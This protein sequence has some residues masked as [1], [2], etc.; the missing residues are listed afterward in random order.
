MTEREAY[1][2][3]NL[4][5]KVGFATVGKLAAQYGSVVAAWEAYPHKISRIGEPV[6]WEKEFSLARKFGVE[7]I[8][9]AD[10]KYPRQLKEAP[11]CPLVLY[12][13]GSVDALSL[14][15]VAM[16]G[17]RRATEYGLGV[18]NRFSYDLCKASWSV[19]SGLALGIDA[20]SHRGALEAK[21]ITVGVIG[22]GLDKFYPQENRELA[23]RIVEQGGA[24]VSEFPFGRPADRATF[25]IRNHVVAALAKGTVAVEAPSRSGTLITAGIAA[26]IGRTVMAVPGRIG[27]RM[28]AG[29]LKLIRDGAIAVRDVDDIIEALRLIAPKRSSN[30]SQEIGNREDSDRPAYTVEEAMVMLHVDDDGISVDELVRETRLPVAKVN[31]LVMTLRVKGFVRFLPGNR[32]ALPHGRV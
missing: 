16:I 3:F 22:S 17:T 24:V 20:E 19:V 12:V 31:S 26:E 30:Q 11:G 9:L 8:T 1:V 13:K 23:R 6:D 5:D 15:S 21:G 32:V 18:A 28:S 2:A 10:E 14:P 27:D 7:V 29:C 4:T 25:P